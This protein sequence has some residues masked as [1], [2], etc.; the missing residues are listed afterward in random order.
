[1]SRTQAEENAMRSIT[2]FMAVALAALFVSCA[3]AADEGVKLVV[4]SSK[5]VIAPFEPVIVTYEIENVSKEPQVVSSLTDPALGWVNLEVSGEDGRLRPYHTGVFGTAIGKDV[6]L[7]PGERRSDQWI[8]LT[9]SLGRG[10]GSP[11]A[12]TDTPPY[13][14][15][16]NP[17]RYTLRVTFP[18][19][20]P[21]DQ[22]SGRQLVGEIS[23]SVRPSRPASEDLKRFA[24]V[25]DLAAAIGADAD[26]D[27]AE[28][29]PRWEQIVASMPRSVFTPFV[30]YNLGESYRL[31]I[32]DAPPDYTRA[33]AHFWAVATSGPQALA[34]DALVGFADSQ[35]KLGNHREAS[36]ALHRV[37]VEF[38]SS[39]VA[40][41]AA[42]L[43]DGLAKH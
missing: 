2:R 37:A 15:F 14:P 36:D 10:G 8:I 25:E 1:M 7:K 39:N 22:G 23:I 43:E 33:A 6:T 21:P 41:R 19:E 32:G 34:D 31:G 5:S 9:N 20:R 28:A 13:F 26:A 30:R 24:S 27:L 3:S 35:I 16:A 42:I 40:R 17:G 18:L 12:V 4:R 38:P 11:P 29:V